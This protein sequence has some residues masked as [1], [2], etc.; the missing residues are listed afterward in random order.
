MGCRTFV[1]VIRFP[2]LL[3]AGLVFGAASSG[4]LAASQ[5]SAAGDDGIATTLDPVTRLIHVRYR[6]PDGVGEECVIR[7]SWSSPG[8]GRRYPAKVT[9]L[10][11]ETGLSLTPARESEAWVGEM[12]IVERRAAGLG[13]TVVFNPYPEAIVDGKVDVDFNIRIESPE[14]QEAVVRNGRVQASFDDV[15]FISDWTRVFQSGAV[16]TKLPD[17]KAGWHVVQPLP[18]AAT[19]LKQCSYLVGSTGPRPGSDAS[20]WDD[21]LPA[22][23]YPLGLRGWHAILVC[24]HESRNDP[25][26]IQLRLTGDERW[27]EMASHYRGEEVFWRWA[28]LDRQH[29]VIRQPRDHRGY[30]RAQIAYV[31]LVPLTA[32]QVAELD[33]QFGRPDKLIAGYWEPYSW[34]FNDDIRETLQHRQPIGAFAEAR[35]GILDTQIGRFGMKS[36]YET[37]LTDQLLYS[38]VGDPVPGDRRPTTDNVGRMQQYTNTLDAT[39]RYAH[40]FGLRPFANFGASN[41]YVGSPLQGDFSRQHPDWIRSGRLRFE[42]PEVRAYALSLYREAMEIGAP[43]I[44][45]DFCRYPQTIDKPETC[46]LFL[47]DLRALADEYGSKR[48]EPVPILVRFPGKGVERWELFDYPTWARQGWVDYLCPSNIQGRHMHIDIGPYVDAVRGTKCT[49]LPCV[50]AL[51]WGLPMPGPYLWRVE[52]LYRAGVAGLYVY[53]ADGRILGRPEDRRCMR[54]IAGSEGVRRFWEEDRRMRLHCSK[55][56]YL[57]KPHDPEGAYQ[58]HERVRVWLEGIEMGEVEFLLDGN[59]VNRCAGPPY[60]LGSEDRESDIVLPRGE[61]RLTVRAR[62]GDGWLEQAFAIKGGR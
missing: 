38:T 19:G 42:V 48:G 34:A 41:C 40:E 16:A 30:Q 44:S 60:L 33:S 21:P 32:E 22:L 43:G 61:H 51:A 18:D 6:V 29:L 62:D 20:G 3:M 53:Q 28:K 15:V 8:T 10:L 52:Q 46:N 9:P 47:K 58:S 4:E 36:V 12:R 55:G 35:V 56:I 27:D 49:L 7:C 14:Q 54:R 26:G 57:S 11:S 23:T 24:T 17:N 59:L 31:K 1:Y 25:G 37:R 45:I 5:R 50:D 13:R 2:L 39:L